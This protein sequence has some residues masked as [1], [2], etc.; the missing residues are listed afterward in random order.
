M[1]FLLPRKALTCGQGS[2]ALEAVPSQTRRTK[3]ILPAFL[4]SVCLI[5]LATGCDTSLAS[6]QNSSGSQNSSG[7]GSLPLVQ[8]YQSDSVVDSI[9]VVTHLSY[10][11]TPYYTAWPQVFNA[12]QTLGV[13]HIRDGY[14]DWDADS[15]FVAEHQQLVSAG[16]RTNYVV[17]FDS[18]TTPQQIQQF[19]SQA[20]DMESLED[21]NECDVA[22]NCGATV[23]EGIGNLLNFL[24]T[25]DAAGSALN[26]PVLGPA[27]TQVPSYLTTGNIAST[28]TYNNLH[29]YFGGRNPGS[30][31]WGAPDAEGNSYGSFAF[32]QDQANIDAPNV[33]TIITETGYMSFCEPVPY[34]I[35][36][37]IEARYIPRT[38]LLAFLGGF[39]RTYVYE[40]LDEQSSP[41]YGLMHSDVSP[42]GA[43]NAIQNLIANLWDLGPSFT[44]G[45]LAYSIQGG[46][47][48]LNQLLLQKRDG[49]FW[50]IL[51]LEQ[52][53]FDTVN[54]VPTPVTPQAVTLTLDSSYVA[55]NIGTFDD[56]GNV[57]WTSPAA[58]SVIPLTITDNLTIV[59]ILPN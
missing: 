25:V 31:G 44:P 50:M 20:Q 35:P 7:N 33:P 12:L 36:E 5:I 10:T 28:M 57:T 24:P 43:Y 13:R 47:S 2:F 55:P 59:K 22:G 51:W 49:S 23:A 21:P 9:G 27:F 54:Y 29:V 3:P 42:K 19:S 1:C 30:S 58:S 15:P 48:T 41:G 6:G 40:L 45:Q 56:N 18:A 38:L 39:K 34:T 17:P 26:V 37:N 4:L 14:Y 46:D 11:N 32:W 8:A 53:G 52:S 16:I